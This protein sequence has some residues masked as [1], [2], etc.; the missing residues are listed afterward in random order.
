A[1]NPRPPRPAGPWR[2]RRP[3]RA[4]AE[5]PPRG[6]PR[7]GAAGLRQLRAGRGQP[8]QRACGHRL[9]AGLRQ[10]RPAAG[11]GDGQR[12]AGRRAAPAGG[13][14]RH[15]GGVRPQPGARGRPLRSGPGVPEAVRRRDSRVSPGARHGGVQGR[16]PPPGRNPARLRPQGGHLRHRERRHLHLHPAPPSPL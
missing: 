15:G 12:A 10:R 6:A 16:N 4:S 1:Q 14:R 7:P 5:R 13:G 8:V 2:R 11:T 9:V 3:A